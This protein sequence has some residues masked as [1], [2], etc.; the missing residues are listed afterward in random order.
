MVVNTASK[1]GL[2][3]QYKQLQEIYETYKDSN[4]VIVG[5]SANNFMS[6]EL[7]NNE[8]IASFCEENYGVTFPMMNKISVKGDDIQEV[9]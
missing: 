8:D 5:F 6:Q 7:G 2:T 1:C 3:S 9:Y 4:F